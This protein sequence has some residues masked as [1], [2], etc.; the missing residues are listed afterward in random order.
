[1][2]LVLLYSLAF[3]ISIFISMPWAL[4]IVTM[5]DSIPAGGLAGAT[6]SD[7]AL[8]Y[9]PINMLFVH[10]F[11][12]PDLYIFSSQPKNPPEGLSIDFITVSFVQK[13]QRPV[14]FLE[15]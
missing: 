1:M 3:L 4:H 14:F 7:E 9:G 12:P 15:A 6:D 5:F 8:L 2:F 10:F 11:P 13:V